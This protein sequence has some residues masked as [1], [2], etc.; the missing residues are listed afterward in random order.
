[1]YDYGQHPS[2]G[3]LREPEAPRRSR[4]EVI[5][6]I[7]LVVGLIA[8]CNP[9][10]GG[11]S[12]HVVCDNAI[13]S[14]SYMQLNYGSKR[15]YA[16]A[17]QTLSLSCEATVERGYLTV[18]VERDGFPLRPLGQSPI[19]RVNIHRSQPATQYEV[20]ISETGLYRIDISPWREP[21]GYDITYDVS[22]R[23]H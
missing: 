9:F 4:R 7:A 21:N 10:L 16:S 2:S 20:P 17:G 14:G 3:I 1:M 11:E 8:W 13:S 19:R 15:I 22:W 23:V 12:S 6:G 5:V 18:D